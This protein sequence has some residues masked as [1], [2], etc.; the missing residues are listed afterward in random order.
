M[1][2][3]L[4]IIIASSAHT[5]RP[6]HK[7]Q[8]G[9]TCS[10]VVLYAA[11]YRFISL[12]YAKPYIENATLINIC[13]IGQG[14]VCLSMHMFLYPSRTMHDRTNAIQSKICDGIKF[15]LYRPSSIPICWRKQQQRRRQRKKNEREKGRK[16]RSNKS[17]QT[18]DRQNIRHII[19]KMRQQPP[20]NNA[21]IHGD[22]ME[23]LTFDAHL[24][25]RNRFTSLRT[26]MWGQCAI[27]I[28]R[29]VGNCG[30]S[31]ESTSKTVRKHVFFNK[32]MNAR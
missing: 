30:H 4:T 12:S 13:S 9:W 3:I 11:P 10:C 23:F 28:Y 7:M 26:R 25:V 19:V 16:E 1:V 18:N 22:F 2:N 14:F 27:H 24:R 8:F 32:P 21:A 5:H 29:S 17:I 20:P 6:Q 31:F 15:V